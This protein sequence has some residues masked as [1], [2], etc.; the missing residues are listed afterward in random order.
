MFEV[1]DYHDDQTFPNLSDS[2]HAFR[3]GIAEYRRGDWDLAVQS[4]TGALEANPADTLASTYITR[5]EQLRADPPADWDG[6]WAMTS[7]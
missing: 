3:D 4:F 1:L 6:V 5:C 7:K 2:V